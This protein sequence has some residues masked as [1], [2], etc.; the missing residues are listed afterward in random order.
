MLFF[1]K[2]LNERSIS[3]KYDIFILW[4]DF[5]FKWKTKT[6]FYS[7]DITNRWTDNPGRLF[8]LFNRNNKWY[9]CESTPKDMY[10]IETTTSTDHD[11]IFLRPMLARAQPWKMNFSVFVMFS[12]YFF[13]NWWIIPPLHI[14]GSI[15]RLPALRQ[16]GFREP[17][18][19]HWRI[20]QLLFFSKKLLGF[21]NL[22]LAALDLPQ[23]MLYE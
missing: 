6:E 18:F 14:I 3:I 10:F 12:Y 21:F 9:F 22:D 16:W 20:C 7:N 19:G 2:R 15:H 8:L 1:N 17:N 23:P 11:T 4:K 5:L 13:E